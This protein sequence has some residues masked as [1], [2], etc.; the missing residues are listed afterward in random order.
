[1][2]SY[3]VKK[4]KHDDGSFNWP[5]C[6]KASIGRSV[7]FTPSCEYESQAY[8][9]DDVNKLFGISFGFSGP[10]KNSAR[11]GW[12]W[13][14]SAQCIELLAY[15]Y[16]NGQRNWDKQMRFPVVAQV[17]IGQRVDCRINYH[18]EFAAPCFSFTVREH[19]TNKVIAAKFEDAPGK[20]P[21]YG[22]T[23]GLYF[24]GALVSPHDITV[25]MEAL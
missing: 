19:E 4:G 12:R 15:V 24:G 25:E 17:K 20:L 6:G 10:H 5:W 18:T 23:H 1:M 9:A 16:V 22:L 3:T 8:N 13:S 2:R 11:F 7:I 21:S 14:K